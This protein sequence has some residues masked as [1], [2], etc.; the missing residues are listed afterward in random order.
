MCD[1]AITELNDAALNHK[2][3]ETRVPYR[4]DWLRRSFSQPGSQILHAGQTQVSIQPP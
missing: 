2:R 4:M 3:I 1:F